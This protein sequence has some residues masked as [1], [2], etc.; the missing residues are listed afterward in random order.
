MDY[1]Y[2]YDTVP[3]LSPTEERFFSKWHLRRVRLCDLAINA[4]N[5]KWNARI[6]RLWHYC[7][8]SR[9]SSPTRPNTVSR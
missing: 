2:D 7:R 8:P 1:E 4:K 5:L 3:D 6:T 9:F